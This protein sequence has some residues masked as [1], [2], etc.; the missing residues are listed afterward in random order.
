MIETCILNF[1]NVFAV[2]LITLFS[3][4]TFAQVTVT[5]CTDNVD[6]DLDGAVDAQ[7]PGCQ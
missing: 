5:K 7:D 3:A 1:R 6:N 4:G 2:A